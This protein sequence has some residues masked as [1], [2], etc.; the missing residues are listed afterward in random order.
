MHSL[1][2]IRN[3]TSD[4]AYRICEYITDGLSEYAERHQHEHTPYE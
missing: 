3:Y 1:G 2:G 4:P